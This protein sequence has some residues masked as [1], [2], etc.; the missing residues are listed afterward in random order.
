MVQPGEPLPGDADLVILPGSKATLA[1]LRDFRRNGWDIDLQAHVRRGGRVLGLC[2]G[3]Q[4]LGRTVADPDGIEG[5]PGSEPGLGLLDVETVLTG[6][7]T[8]TEVV[9]VSAVSDVPFRGYEM[10]VGRTDGPDC[11]RPLLCFADGRPDGAI[12]TD[13]RV[14]ATYVHG[15]FADDRQRAA[16]L[17]WLGGSSAGL[18]YEAEVDR[19]LDALAD[20]LTRHIDLDRLLTIAR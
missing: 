8:L 1:D 5:P 14:R 3:Y 16:W 17:S 13:G 9:G 11:V 10:H 12:S 7:K 2:G 19:V 4:M 6:D 18:N 15:L 20:H